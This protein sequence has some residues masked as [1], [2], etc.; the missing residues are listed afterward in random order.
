MSARPDVALIAPYPPRGERHGGHSG[1][2]SYAA[3]LADALADHGVHVTV[4]APELDGDPTHF[5]DGS[6]DVN[7][8][9][10][11]GRRALPAAMAAAAATGAPIV[12]LQFE[13]FLYGGAASL[14]GLPAALGRARWAL[15]RVVARDD[16]APDRRPRSGRPPTMS[17][18]TAWGFRRRSPAPGSPPCKRGRPSECGDDRPR[19]RFPPDRPDRDRDP[20]WHRGRD[21]ARPRRG[22][23]TSRTRR[24]LHRAVLRLPRPV[25]GHRDPFSPPPVSPDPTFTSWS[26]AATTR[27]CNGD[28]WALPPRCG[29]ST[30]TWRRSPDGSPTRTS[31]RG[32]A[33][34]T[35]P[36]SRIP[37]PFSSSGALA[38]A[39]AHGT[40]A[41]LS[42][43]LAR[44]AGAPSVMTVPMEPGR[45]PAGSTSSP[46]RRRPSTSCA[47]GRPTLASGRRWPTIAR[48]HAG[49]YEEV[50]ADVERACSSAPSGRV[51]PATKHCA[52]RSSAPWPTTRSS[53]PAVTR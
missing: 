28:G 35:S 1:V 20:P 43:P 36:S 21:A 51:I 31:R 9:F 52:R 30:A 24:T 22:P 8:A 42:P 37:R 41:V 39:L 50:I 16:A 49:L 11:N 4:V 2:A 3:N 12:H 34:P 45:W 15:R 47:A 33:P 10:G 19:G 48:H 44:C 40:A 7:R 53:S 29:R 5:S 6:V 27:G 17:G 32:S 13:L 38:L 23:P 18:S 26:R 46:R 14:F 25:Q